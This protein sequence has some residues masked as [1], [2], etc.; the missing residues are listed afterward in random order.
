MKKLLIFIILLTTFNANANLDYGNFRKSTN[1]NGNVG[2]NII[3]WNSEE[4]IKLFEEAYYKKDFYNL[5]HHFEPQINP[6]YCGIASITIILNALNQGRYDIE[7]LNISKRPKKYGG[8]YIEFKK[9]TQNSILNKETDKIKS[10]KVINFKRKHKLYKKYDPGLT[11]SD[12]SE[13]MQ[14]HDLS[15][16]TFYAKEDLK[17][18]ISEFKKQLIRNLNEKNRYIIAN[19]YGPIF[20]GLTDGHI[21]PI[22]AYN[23]KKNK[24]LILEVASHKQPW[25]WVDIDLFYQAMQ[26][27]D[28]DKP[29]GFIVATK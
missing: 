10:R 20:G 13:I 9:Y 17:S 3:S 26:K 29:R 4:G 14:S 23:R 1:N 19:F 25:N 22:V 6:L 18:G 16:Q 21:S 12:L 7:S 2:Y 5:A 28:I 11:L 8:E 15:T 27:V 24:I